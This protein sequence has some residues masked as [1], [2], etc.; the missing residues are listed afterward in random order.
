MQDKKEPLY[1]E[2]QLLARVDKFSSSLVPGLV[3]TAPP[4]SFHP[5]HPCPTPLPTLHCL[6]RRH[7][8]SRTSSSGTVFLHCGIQRKRF[9]SGVGYNGRGVRPVWIHQRT[10]SGCF[11]PNIFCCIKQSRGFFSIVPHTGMVSLPLLPTAQKNLCSVSHTAECSVPLG[12]TVQKNDTKNYIFLLKGIVS[13]DFRPLVFYE[14]N[15]ST[16]LIQNLKPF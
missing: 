6:Q 10:I 1:L 2:G 11:L 14:S 7:Q 5:F 8:Q 12:D 16:P 13:R 15:L 4:F 3:T 9:F